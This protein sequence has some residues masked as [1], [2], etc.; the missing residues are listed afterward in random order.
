MDSATEYD[1]L[2]EPL[3]TLDKHGE[4]WSADLPTALAL[5]SRGE[6]IEFACLQQH[7]FHP[8][9]AFLVQLAAL[10]LEKGGLGEP[11]GEPEPWRS[12]LAELAS[13]HQTAFVLVNDDLS[14]PAFM[15]P[16]VPEGSLAKFKSGGPFPSEIETLIT[17][18]SHELKAG[19]IRLSRAEHWVYA[20]V[21]LQTSE[22]FLGAGNYGISRMNGGFGNRP[23]VAIAPATR[24]VDRFLRDV[25]RLLEAKDDVVGRHGYKATGLDLLWCLAWDGTEALA[26]SDLHPYFIEI[27]RRVRLRK[28]DETVRVYRQ[29]TRVARVDSAETLGDLGDPWTPVQRATKKALT[30]AGS[31][32]HYRVLHELILGDE[33]APGIAGILSDADG[34]EPVFLAAAMARGQGKTEGPFHREIPIPAIVRGLLGSVD[35]KARVAQRSKERIDDAAKAR[36]KVL[37]PTLCAQLQGRPR[38]LKLDDKRTER[39]LEALEASVDTAF[40]S[41]L[42]RDAELSPEEA[43]RRWH[44]F[45]Y[46]RCKALVAEAERG[47]PISSGSRYRAMAAGQQVL[48]ATAYKHLPGAFA[49]EETDAEPR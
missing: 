46:E 12:L 32:L 35:G 1:L 7:Q 47:A 28:A 17:A 38:D 23:G 9:F 45:L 39:W 34:P 21:A 29:P 6:D 14:E 8:W 37:H 4:R 36:R 27:C 16:P 31:G 2:R 41:E 44:G 11:P 13:P 49:E 19:R 48:R 42:W 43:Q 3:L 24:C 33:Y 22:G 26:I 30:V 18:K 5:L 20:L 15:Q 25:G 40:F 10:A